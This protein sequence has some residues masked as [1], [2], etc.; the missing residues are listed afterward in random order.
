MVLDPEACFRAL[1]SRDR[2]FEGRFF[3]G[4]ATTGIYCRPGCPARI[5]LRK[6]VHFFASAAAAE[7]AGLRPCRRCRPDASPGS[8]ARLGT[9]A[10]VF[11]ALRLIGDG[12]LDDDGVDELAARLGVGARHLRRLFVEH[13]G[14]PPLAVAHAQ[15]VHF[16]R[17][18]IVETGLSMADV[19]LASGFRSVRRFNGAMRAVYR[20]PPSEM[21]AHTHTH[22]KAGRALDGARPGAGVIALKLPFHP[23]L[24]FETM[25]EF[26]RARAIAGV[27]AVA[28]GEYSRTARIDGVPVIVSVRR[29]SEQSLRLEIAPLGGLSRP[30]A[31]LPRAVESARR[32]F[33]LAADPASINRVLHRDALLARSVSA[34][35]GLR[36]VGAWDPFELAVRAIVGQQVTVR[37]ASTIASR[38]AGMFGPVI[39]HA[40]LGLSRLFPAPSILADADLARTGLTRARAEAI[41]ALARAV[42]SRTVAFDAPLGIDDVVA[43]FTAIRGIGPW[44]AHM[45]AMRGLGEPD[46]FPIADRALSLRAEAWRPWRSYA[47]MHLL[48]RSQP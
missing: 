22:T 6:N 24:A 19:A 40:P 46:A 23:P 25:L 39:E 17:K 5:P 12:G 44:T 1:A 28:S 34:R 30:L 48:T 14:A 4:V 15:K 8:P 9:P 36:V 47:A 41:R 16:A 13:L 11:R 10:T 31:S 43:R 45:I 33:D 35:P 38:I 42:A 20:I 18:L 21:R 32:L 7:L 2:R 27:E 26:L 29:A 37:G 3:V